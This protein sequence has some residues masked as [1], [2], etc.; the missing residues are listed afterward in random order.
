MPNRYRK[1][2]STSPVTRRLISQATA[3][4]RLSARDRRS[5]WRLLSARCRLSEPALMSKSTSTN[6][7][8]L[9]SPLLR[10]EPD[11]L[12][13]P[14][15]RSRPLLRSGVILTSPVLHYPFKKYFNSK[16][17]FVQ[18]ENITGLQNESILFPKCLMEAHRT[19]RNT[20]VI[21]RLRS[22]SLIN[23]FIS[24]F[25]SSSWIKS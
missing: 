11:L 10:S 1:K 6:A 4:D 13:R 23:N 12:S 8:L 19:V 2:S 25:L 18:Y 9:S 16:K 17:P 14:L 20:S 21:D 7:S 22:L 5:G 24:P 3:I 15:R